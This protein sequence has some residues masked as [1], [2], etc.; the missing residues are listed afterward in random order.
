[1]IQPRDYQIDVV[2]RLRRAVAAGARRVILQ[3]ATGSGKTT[4]SSMLVKAAL[5]KQKRVLFLA[6]RRRLIEQKAERL[7][8]FGVPYGILMAGEHRSNH[9]VQI[10]S[11]DTLFSRAVRNGWIGF[12]P[13]DLVIVD[14]CHTSLNQYA[15]MMRQYPKAVIVGLTATPTRG[16]GSGLGGYFDDIVC[17]VPVSKLIEDGYIVPVSC[18]AP[19]R[20]ADGG[21][22]EL[23]GDVVYHWRMYG[24]NKPTV[25]FATDTDASKSAVNAFNAAGIPAVHIDAYTNDKDRDAAIE[26]LES[27]KIKVVGNCAIWGEGVDVPCLTVCI[28][29]RLA[30]SYIT[31]AQCVGRI[32]RPYQGKERAILIDHSGA[33][34]QH[35]FP[36]EDVTW[37]LDQDETVDERVQRDKKEGKRKEPICCPKCGY[38]YS[39]AMQCPA[40]GY[41]LFQAPK[42]AKKKDELLFEVSRDDAVNMDRADMER[43]WQTCLGIQ[44]N[45]GGKVVAAFAMFK[46]KYPSG[47]T[48]GFRHDPPSGSYQK[49]VAEVFPGF[50]RG[51]CHA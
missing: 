2:D 9:P 26:G 37:T 18:Y 7:E 1:M 13:A 23:C 46:K 22:R 34:F 8:Q 24:Q 49:P 50:V 4:C 28:L 35:G 27:G 10:A 41:V 44:A 11:R 16:D 32:M 14:E 36:D 17:T 33:V 5:E 38:L 39:G 29:L 15:D 40:C 47:S 45:R 25:L 43:Y 42:K 3:G 19:Q 21:K 20:K 12:P 30:S 6:H 48:A 51:K 31:F